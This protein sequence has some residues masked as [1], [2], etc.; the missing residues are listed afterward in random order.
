MAPAIVRGR[1][2]A[3][4]VVELAAPFLTGRHSTPPQLGHGAGHTRRR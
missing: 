2:A 4:R 3:M 1:A